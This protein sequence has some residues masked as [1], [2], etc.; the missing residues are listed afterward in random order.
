M[1]KTLR[2]VDEVIEQLG[3]VSQ[4]AR[5]LGV[6]PSA[7]S[8][9]KTARRIPAVWYRRLRREFLEGRDMLIDDAVFDFRD[10]EPPINAAAL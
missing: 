7:V 3:G 2:T 9:W 6:T 5:H 1:T 10:I 4:T 8:Q